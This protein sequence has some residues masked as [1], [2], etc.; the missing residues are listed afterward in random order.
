[1]WIFCTGVWLWQGRLSLHNVCVCVYM[2]VYTCMRVCVCVYIYTCV[3]VCMCSWNVKGG[4]GARV[5]AEGERTER[6]DSAWK[7][8]HSFWWACVCYITVHDGLQVLL[9]HTHQWRAPGGDQ[10]SGGDAAQGE[11][12]GTGQGFARCRLEG[13]L[14]DSRLLYDLIREIKTWLN[15]NHFTVHK[16]TYF[17]SQRTVTENTYVT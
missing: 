14:T 4:G 16:N 7:L 3:C 2:N 10:G 6:N 17:K 15:I 5:W 13:K 9:Q 11:P 12:H 1:M 8:P